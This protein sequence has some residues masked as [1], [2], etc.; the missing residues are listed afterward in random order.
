MND[1]VLVRGLE[2][3]RDLPGDGERFVERNR[4]VCNAIR[5][6]RPFHELEDQGPDAVSFFESV[7]RG[8]VRMIERREHACFPLESREAIRIVRESIRQD[9]ERHVAAELS[10]VGALDFAHA[11]R[12]DRGLHFVRA[13]TC[14][15]SERHEPACERRDYDSFRNVAPLV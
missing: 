8:D 3:L 4:S 13:E 11:A 1:S 7:D 14:T 6:R 2:G 9:F 5:E 12:A 10:V 15:G